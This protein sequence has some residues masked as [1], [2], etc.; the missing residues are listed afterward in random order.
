M[1]K[2]LTDKESEDFYKNLSDEE[3]RIYRSMIYINILSNLLIN[4]CIHYELEEYEDLHKSEY[5]KTRIKKALEAISKD[6]K[7]LKKL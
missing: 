1:D 3:K 7:I 6:L 4:Y 5:H 2:E